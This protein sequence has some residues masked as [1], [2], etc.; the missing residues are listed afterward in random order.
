MSIILYFF[1]SNIFLMPTPVWYKTIARLSLFEY[2]VFVE[3]DVADGG[4]QRRRPTS[5]RCPHPL[6]CV[7]GRSLWR[8]P[9]REA[10]LVDLWRSPFPFVLNF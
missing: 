10:A 7:G 5:M 3:I 6:R 4:D 2:C 8:P 9:S 1:L